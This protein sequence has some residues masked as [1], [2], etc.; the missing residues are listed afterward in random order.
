MEAVGSGVIPHPAVFSFLYEQGCETE[1]VR[2]EL[3]IPEHLA[4]RRGVIVTEL[5]P[6]AV[7]IQSEDYHG[8]SKCLIISTEGAVCTGQSVISIVLVRNAVGT[9]IHLAL[10][11][12]V[13]AQDS[14]R[15]GAIY[16]GGKS[17]RAPSEEIREVT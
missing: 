14:R 6:E 15:P 11:G 12:S 16:R 10:I 13:L 7:V 4:E 17:D 3:V 1:K 2:V 5:K 8:L 9:H